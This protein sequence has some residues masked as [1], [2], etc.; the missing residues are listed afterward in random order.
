MGISYV[1]KI[2]SIVC[3]TMVISWCSQRKEVRIAACPTFWDVIY[4]MD[5]LG[6]E[7]QS[8]SES[9]HLLNHGY[10]DYVLAGRTPKPWEQYG[11]Y[12]ILWS[13]YSFLSK[14]SQTISDEE[15]QTIKFFTDLADGENIKK[16][17]WIKNLEKVENIYDYSETNIIITSW[18]NTD[19]SKADVVHVSHTSWERYIESRIP[20]L[21]CRN[22]CEENIIAKSFKSLKI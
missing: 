7:T 1:V 9:L 17:F 12:K 13:G 21:Y 14:E 20:I 10:V 22:K 4:K 6:R 18:D 19:Y 15:L 5:L 8:T 3:I 2:L 16:I 11:D